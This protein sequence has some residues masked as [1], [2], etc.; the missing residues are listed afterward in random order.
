M[1]TME[2]TH[3]QERNELSQ[4]LFDNGFS[5]EFTGGGCE[6][7]TLYYKDYVIV[8]TD[9]SGCNEFT[10]EGGNMLGVYL[11]GD[12]GWCDH[13]SYEMLYDMDNKEDIQ[14][15]LNRI[16]LNIN[17]DVYKKQDEMLKA[18]EELRDKKHKQ[19]NN[20]ANEFMMLFPHLESMSLDEF[21]VKY[22]DNLTHEER[23]AGQSIVDMF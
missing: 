4:V 18:E 19:L 7:Q 1:H 5:T 10:L 12:D 14:R 23:I 13:N 20:L 21:I 22:W 17:C 16:K 9:E 2:S 15:Q 11:D 6:A 8:G 3:T